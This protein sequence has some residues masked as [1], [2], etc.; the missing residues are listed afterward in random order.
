MCI[1]LPNDEKTF[2]VTL[3]MSNEPLSHENEPSFSTIKSGADA[4]ALFQRD[5]ADAVPL[6]PD[7]E[8]DWERNP[9]GL[10]ATLY[11]ER[12][13]IDHR[14]VLLGD[15]AHAMVPFHG[16]GMNCAFEDCVVLARKLEEHTD[17]AEAFAA[18]QAKRR[19]NALAIQQMALENY[20]EMRDRVDDPDFLLQRELELALQDRHPGRFVPH[21][22]MVTFMLIPYSV[23]L[24]RSD[25]QR[26]ILVAATRGKD[27]LDDIDWEATDADVM[28]RLDVLVDAA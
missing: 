15:A 19:P 13:H 23:A 9:P 25:I 3:F 8:Q 2:T 6:I 17:L 16:Q 12:W 10:L 1:A 20:L 26:E 18:F 24:A 14:A 28:A 5:F 27:S 21:Y 22:T 4:K 7:L 11:L